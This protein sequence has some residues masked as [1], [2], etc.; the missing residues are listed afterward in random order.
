MSLRIKVNVKYP[1]FLKVLSFI[2][3]YFFMLNS[4]RLSNIELLRKSKELNIAKYQRIKL[5]PSWNM[6]IHH[7]LLFLLLPTIAIAAPPTNFNDAKKISFKLFSIHKQTLYCQCNYK[8]NK[9]I[10]LT[11]CNMEA[12][13]SHTRSHNIEWEHIVP[14]SKLATDHACWTKNICQHSSGKKYHGRKCCEHIDKDFRLAESEL[15]N[16]WPANGLINQLRENYS[17]AALPFTD[18]A[19]GCK[20]IVDNFNHKIEPSDESKGIVAR[21]SLFIFKKNHLNL[22]KKQQDLFNLWDLLYPPREWE[23]TWAK[24]VAKIEGYDNPYIA[25]YYSLL[26]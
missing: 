14:A 19:Y 20:F 16:L 3:R 2:H 15:Y 12:A 17:Y 23:L 22:N 24:K 8:E 9:N 13:S 25:K 6:G 7:L 1:F 18:Y 26:S 10:S 4:L 11:S 21:A 5:A